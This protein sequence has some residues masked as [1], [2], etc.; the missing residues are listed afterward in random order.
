MAWVGFGLGRAQFG[1]G[2]VWVCFGLVWIGF[3]LQSHPRGG[4][5]RRRRARPVLPFG[6]RMFAHTHGP[7]V[8]LSL[9][10]HFMFKYVAFV[11]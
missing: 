2:V 5:D 10:V 6:T 8:A 1:F 9:S 11:S 7:G 3:W 4:R